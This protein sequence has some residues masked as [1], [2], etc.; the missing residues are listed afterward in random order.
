MSPEA[1]EAFASWMEREALQHPS[2]PVLVD[3]L[4]V[5]ASLVR[6]MGARIT[7]AEKY[8][9]R[10]RR[11]QRIQRTCNWIT[12]TLGVV[13]L[14]LNLYQGQPLWAIAWLFGL[15]SA[16]RDLAETRQK[17]ITI[18]VG[19]DT[20]EFE[21]AMAHLRSAITVRRPLPAEGTPTQ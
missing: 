17:V 7:M 15:W 16:C 20:V 1:V 18:T 13:A 5:G 21:K 19:V 3:R 6:S 12:I 14:P 4:A 8:L 9:R 2:A 11:F 10:H